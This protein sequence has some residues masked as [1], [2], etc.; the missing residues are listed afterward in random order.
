MLDLFSGLVVDDSAVGLLLRIQFKKAK[1]DLVVVHRK[2]NNHKAIFIR[3]YFLYTFN[4]IL[5]LISKPKTAMIARVPSSKK[6]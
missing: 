6:A 2:R 5:S 4:F 3:K 1:K